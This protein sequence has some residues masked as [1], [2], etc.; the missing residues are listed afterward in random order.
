LK[1]LAKNVEKELGPDSFANATMA[2]IVTKYIW[3]R[4]EEANMSYA[5]MVNLQSLRDID[6][7]VSHA[8][9]EN[10]PTFVQSVEQAL[11]QR[12][13]ADQTNLWICSFALF[14]S[15]NAALIAEQLGGDLMDAPFDKALRHA[16]EV[17]VVRNS[18]TDNYSRAWCVYEIFRARQLALKISITGPDT[19]AGGN[20]DIMSCEASDPTDADKIKDAIKKAG[21][22]HELNDVVT[23]I[24]NKGQSAVHGSVEALITP[25][26]KRIIVSL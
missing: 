4:T 18:Q 16:K 20:V 6:I 19:F 22:E 1:E 17:L 25:K 23:E 3:N 7:F 5:R 15:Q 12:L 21:L 13:E 2:D 10:F 9:R 24:K 14:Q 11:S 8:W 26:R